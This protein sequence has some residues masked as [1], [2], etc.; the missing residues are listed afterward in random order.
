VRI[1]LLFQLLLTLKFSREEGFVLSSQLQ[2]LKSLYKE[3]KA[4]E[5]KTQDKSDAQVAAPQPSESPM[6]NTPAVGD[7][8]NE[9]DTNSRRTESPTYCSASE[10]FVTATK[11]APTKVP[12]SRLH[13]GT[14]RRPKKIE[15]RTARRARENR[16]RIESRRRPAD[17]LC[18]DKDMV[19][20]LSLVENILTSINSI[21]YVGIDVKKRWR[22]HEVI[23]GQ[24]LDH[25]Y[26]LLEPQGPYTP[27]E[28]AACFH[29][30]STLKRHWLEELRRRGIPSI[31][32]RWSS[33][34]AEYSDSD[35]DYGAPIKI[36]KAQ[37]LPVV[38][39][40]SGRHREHSPD[41]VLVNTNKY[42]PLPTEVM[43]A[44]AS[45]TSG[46]P[47][48]AINNFYA[49]DRSRSHSRHRRDS[50][51]SSD[52]HRSRSRYREHHVRKRYTRRGALEFT[53]G[54]DADDDNVGFDADSEDITALLQSLTTLTPEEI[55]TSLRISH[56]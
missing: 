18:E 25:I 45:N 56:G 14:E 17:P 27:Q 33:P 1:P 41:T 46:R 5:T 43:R 37:V 20:Y 13:D 53:T 39:S 2:V 48:P 8:S 42:F 52:S 7:Q 54:S 38:R 3:Q 16:F 34:S 31:R 4:V 6:E 23:L 47:V 11:N 50:S 40:R 9:H 15:K 22:L 28:V 36:T 29:E 10:G 12:V 32:S 51:S 35:S 49:D 21:E 30:G 55:A 19:L 44:R 24:Y 26:T